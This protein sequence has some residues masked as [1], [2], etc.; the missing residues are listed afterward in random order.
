MSET[1]QQ[2][3]VDSTALSGARRGAFQCVG[4]R[5]PSETQTRLKRLGICEGREVSVLQS[6]DP[7]ILSVVGSQVAVS[8]HLAEEI[9]VR[10]VAESLNDE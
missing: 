6:G 5:G 2:Q 4:V 8:R 1:N 10:P 3:T 9:Q 7:M